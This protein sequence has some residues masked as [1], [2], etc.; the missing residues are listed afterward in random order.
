MFA[1]SCTSIGY[2]LMSISF[3]LCL[4]IY[5]FLLDDLHA[6]LSNVI[7]TLEDMPADGEDKALAKLIKSLEQ[8]RPLNGSGLFT[9]ER[10]TLTSMVSTAITYLIIL[11]Q[12]KLSFN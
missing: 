3:L 5:T 9:I 12:F 1:L 8:A 6:S 4:Q 11:V 2:F 10:S 7:D